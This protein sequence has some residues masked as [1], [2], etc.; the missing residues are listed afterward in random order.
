[1]T[2]LINACRNNGDSR[3]VND[4]YVHGVKTT[5]HHTNILEI[6]LVKSEATGC[7]TYKI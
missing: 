4:D 1:L 6:S 3:Y 2:P 5:I 7:E